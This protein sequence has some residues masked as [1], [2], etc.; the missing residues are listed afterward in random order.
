M[1]HVYDESRVIGDR[2][3]QDDFKLH[4][5]FWVPDVPARRIAG[6]LT[7]SDGR[8]ELALIG[9]FGSPWPPLSIG[10]LE[11]ILGT[12]DAGACTLWKSHATETTHR[13]FGQTGVARSRFVS[14]FLFLGE[15]FESADRIQFE[16]VRFSFDA[17]EE[18][19]ATVPFV[20]ESEPGAGDERAQPVARH[21][22]PEAFEIP[23]P[24][25][26][27]SVSLSLTFTQGG[28][29]F[30]SLVWTQRAALGIKAEGEAR[31]FEWF[32]ERLQHLRGLLS[33][34]V[35]EPVL[36]TGVVGRVPGADRPSV[37][38]FFPVIGTPRERRLH[39]HQMLLSRDKLGDRLATAFRRWFENRERLQ[40]PASLFLGTLYGQTVPLEFQ[41]LAL[42]QALESFH[43]RFHDGRYLAEEE[44]APVAKALV[45]AIPSG[46]P[47]DLGQSLKSRIRYGNE[48]S[49][50]RRFNELLQSLG[51]AGEMTVASGQGDFVQ[52]VVAER[53]RL[54]HHAQTPEHPAMGMQTLNESVIRL[55]AFLTLLL[56]VELG[57][58]RD[59][60]SG[61][62]GQTQWYRGF[63][64]S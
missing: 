42:T 30:R 29:L 31:S 11:I 15:S 35:G 51:A 38:V 24:T 40:T 21:V 50:R 5:D 58:D 18:W 63:L 41:F 37:E 10:P 7:N 19:L 25:E 54:T 4:G 59:E 1:A 61:L 16:E 12:T 49:Q 9:A 20:H 53:N 33:L 60:A 17:L 55:R 64:G 62:V 52:R 56:L 48:Y 36:P 26:A 34:L 3:L 2:G 8:I 22:F 47:S 43:R 28:E 27:A 39:P 44:Y 32:L 13:S 46:L 57:I 6:T 14:T 23:L 45:S